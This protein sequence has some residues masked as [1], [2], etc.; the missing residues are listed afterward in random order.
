[1]LPDGRGWISMVRAICQQQLTHPY[2]IRPLNGQG[3]PCKTVADAADVQGPRAS[4]PNAPWMHHYWQLGGR[5]Q[6]AC[7]GPLLGD[8]QRSTTQTCNKTATIALTLSE[9]NHSCVTGLVIGIVVMYYLANKC[10]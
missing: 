6:A 10:W 2:T 8:N 5:P 9:R 4:T 7:V 1:M 3:P